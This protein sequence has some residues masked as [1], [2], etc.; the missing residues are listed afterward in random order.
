MD[1]SGALVGSEVG[2]NTDTAGGQSLVFSTLL[3]DGRV[4]FGWN[5]TSPSPVESDVRFS[6][7]KFK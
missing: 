7:L 2:V 4:L 3:K 1:A 5:N 6:M